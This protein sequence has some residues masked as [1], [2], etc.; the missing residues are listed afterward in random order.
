MKIKYL[1]HFFIL[2][3]TALSPKSILIAILPI[4]LRYISITINSYSNSVLIVSSFFE[5]SKVNVLISTC[6]CAPV[7]LERT[8]RVELAWKDMLVQ[9]RVHFSGLLEDNSKATS[10]RQINTSIRKMTQTAIGVQF[11]CLHF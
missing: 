2:T 7:D 10:Y 3:Q 6:S 4:S 5:L 9:F 11:G 1:V 8:F